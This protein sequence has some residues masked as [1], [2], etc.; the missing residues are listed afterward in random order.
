MPETTFTVPLSDTARLQAAVRAARRARAIASRQE[1]DR[2]AVEL[3]LRRPEQE[4]EEALLA[5]GLSTAKF[6]LSDWCRSQ[7]TAFHPLEVQ[8]P[9]L[10]GTDARAQDGSGPL[11][12]IGGIEGAA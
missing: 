7:P 2:D 11:Q 6:E 10:A 3:M 9:N 12:E 8:R 5:A 4:L 1:F